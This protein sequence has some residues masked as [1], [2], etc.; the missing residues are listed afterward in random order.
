MIDESHDILKVAIFSLPCSIFWKDQLGFWG[1]QKIC[2]DSRD[3][4]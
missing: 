2:D 4:C 3:N 1:K